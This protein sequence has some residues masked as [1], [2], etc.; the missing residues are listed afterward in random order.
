MQLCPFSCNFLLC[1]VRCPTQH[2]LLEHLCQCYSFTVIDQVLHPCCQLIL[3]SYLPKFLHSFCCHEGCCP[4]AVLKNVI[5]VDLSHFLSF[6][7]RVLISPSCKRIGRASALYTFMLE[8]YWT[9]KGLKV[10][11]RIP[12]V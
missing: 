4:A 1:R 2:S 11:F 3:C 6:F 7:L 9:S 8:N 5:S 10:S 12:I